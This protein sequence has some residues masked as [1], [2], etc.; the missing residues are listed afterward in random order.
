MVE[1]LGEASRQVPRRADTLVPHHQ[2]AGNDVGRCV[3]DPVRRPAWA[4]V[5][6]GERRLRR[7]QIG[8][9]IRDAVDVLAVE[10]LAGRRNAARQPVIHAEVAAPDLGELEIRLGDVQLKAARALPRDVRR[11][12]AIR[13][14]AERID[15]RIARRLDARDLSD[16]YAGV[17]QLI[18]DPHIERRT[19]ECA[20]AHAHLRPL[21]SADVPVHRHA[22]RPQDLRVGHLAGL[23]LHRVPVLVTEGQGVGLGVLIRGVLERGQIEPEASGHR[24]IPAR[25]PFVLDVATAVP[26]FEL[27]ERLI[28]VRRR[29]MYRTLKLRN[30]PGMPVVRF[31]FAAAAPASA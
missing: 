1:R 2:R 20:G 22:R 17:A 24:E 25:P 10:E 26:D 29:S 15:A 18:R 16:Q 5:D 6:A 8:V 4:V 23:V 11:L 30:A 19:G 3:V 14:R 12:V 27:L 28:E 31:G 7:R 9:D 21:L 13:I